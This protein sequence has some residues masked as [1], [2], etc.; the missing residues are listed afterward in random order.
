MNKYEPAWGLDFDQ[1]AAEMVRLTEES[2]ESVSMEFNDIAVVAFPGNNVQ[3]LCSQYDAAWTARRDAY[4]ASPEYAKAQKEYAEKE[5]ARKK[6]SEE[7]LALAPQTFTLR[8]KRTGWKKMWRI[9]SDPYGRYVMVFADQW[10]RIM[11]YRMAQGETLEAC[12]EEASH[13]ADTDGLSGF[14]YG[15]AVGILS[16][17]WIH[18]EQLRKWHNGEY[19]VKDADGVVNPA[20]VTLSVAPEVAES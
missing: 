12:A 18:G 14:Q 2:G 16:R 17:C 6:A 4:L 8:N 10:A 15:V 19:G 5:A 20:L 9:N 7:A 3:D 11:E 1:A 13:L